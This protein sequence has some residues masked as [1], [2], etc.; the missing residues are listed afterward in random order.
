MYYDFCREEEYSYYTAGDVW[1]GTWNVNG[2]FSEKEIEMWLGRDGDSPYSLY[3]VGL[4]EM[5]PLNPLT[6][7]FNIH[8]KTTQKKWLDAIQSILEEKVGCVVLVG[9]LHS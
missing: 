1:V 4:Q 7:L 2:C 5:V 8:V 6:V 9:S 3:A